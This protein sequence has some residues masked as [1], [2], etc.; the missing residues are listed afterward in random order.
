MVLNGLTHHRTMSNEHDAAIELHYKSYLSSNRYYQHYYKD[1]YSKMNLKTLVL[2]ASTLSLTEAFSP[3]IP[4]RASNKSSSTRLHIF[5][6]ALK[7]AFGNDDALGKAQNAG[8]TNVTPSVKELA[9]VF[10]LVEVMGRNLVFSFRQVWQYIMFQ[11][12]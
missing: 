12:D 5:G 4:S 1:Y 3:S 10:L 2:I 9:S 11:K 7:N 8:L 6:D